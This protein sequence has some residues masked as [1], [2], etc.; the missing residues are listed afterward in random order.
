L[1]R[2]SASVEVAVLAPAFIGLIV[3][4][5]VVG[6]T[7]IARETIEVAAHDA[8]RAASISRSADS[9]RTAATQAVR[10]RLEWEGLS[11]T[12]VPALDFAGTVDGTTVTLDQ[13]F[14]ADLGADVTVFVRVACTVSVAD[15]DLNVLDLRNTDVSAA[16]VSPLDRYRARS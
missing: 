13:A 11:C 10:D 9:A 15:L 8:A 14:D 3:L 5:G 1:A 4:A 7:A 6:R 12:G 2:G 16:F